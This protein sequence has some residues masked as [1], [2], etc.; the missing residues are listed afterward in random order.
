M[1]PKSWM[2]PSQWEH[3]KR[4]LS[5]LTQ[6]EGVGAG[7][8]E[9]KLAN[10]DD[11]LRENYRFIRNDEGLADSELTPE[12]RLARQ[13]YQKLYKEYCIGDMSRYKSGEVGLRWRTEEEVLS[14]KGKTVCGSKGCA[15]T[16][17][18]KPFEVDFE[19]PEDGETKRALV[20]LSLCPRC[21]KK[22]SY[23]ND[24]KKKKEKER[25][26]KRKRRSHHHHHHHHR[27]KS[28]DKDSLDDDDDN[29]SKKK[30]KL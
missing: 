27:N 17:G 4:D 19:Y 20:K 30:I 26:L 15:S 22:L 2:T 9:K 16:E 8:E 3:Y 5:R 14:G 6:Q 28:K 11:V 24:K 18:L 23:V 21:A 7:G 1:N 25:K 13:Y 12:Q 10:D 29:L